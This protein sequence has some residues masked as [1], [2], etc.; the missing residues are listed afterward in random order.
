MIKLTVKL[1]HSPF[2]RKATSLALFTLGMKRE[3]ETLTDQNKMGSSQETPIGKHEKMSALEL[4]QEAVKV[5]RG[6]LKALRKLADI[7]FSN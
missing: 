6:N 2:M 5:D 1:P 4:F 7:E 3:Q